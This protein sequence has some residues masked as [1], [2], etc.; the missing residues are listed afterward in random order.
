M[1]VPRGEGWGH[2]GVGCLGVAACSRDG[3]RCPIELPGTDAVAA[4]QRLRAS[5]LDGREDRERMSGSLDVALVCGGGGVW[6]IAWMIGIAAGLSDE[7][8]DLHSATPIIGTSAGSVVG[9]LLASGVPASEMFERQVD[10]AKQ[11]RELT[12][13]PGRLEALEELSTRNWPSDRDRL[14][15]IAEFALS[16][17]T[18]SLAER[19]RTIADRLAPLAGPW[20]ARRLLV[21]AV[22]VETLELEVLDGR[23]GASLVDAVAA[24]CAVP[25]VWPM[26]PIGARRYV[27]GGTWRTAENAHLAEGSRRVLILAPM[28]GIEVEA[29]RKDPG[30]TADVAYLEAHGSKVLVIA[31]DDASLS[32]MAGDPLD[33][34]RRGP[35]AW[36]GRRQGAREA[37]RV[38]EF[39]EQL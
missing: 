9:A 4:S 7:G 39:I 8:V 16:A 24:S 3:R 2:H 14:Q 19:R 38:R 21:T 33:P 29:T 23:S 5:F 25:G 10:P 17:E 1:G 13:P 28:A 18:A 34:A 35:G 15:A 6:G 22:D 26:V 32:A 27:D 37:D 20:P 11:P 36:A 31:A 30:L 12:A